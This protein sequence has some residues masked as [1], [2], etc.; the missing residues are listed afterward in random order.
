SNYAQ[1]PWN[2]YFNGELLPVGSYYYIIEPNDGKSNS[3]NGTV[4]IILK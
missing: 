4:S 2:G 1:K 3:M